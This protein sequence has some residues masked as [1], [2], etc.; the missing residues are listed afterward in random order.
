MSYEILNKA[1]DVT[2]FFNKPLHKVNKILLSYAVNSEELPEW[3]RGIISLDDLPRFRKDGCKTNIKVNTYTPEKLGQCCVLIV[4]QLTGGWRIDE[5][6]FHFENEM[7][8]VIFKL[9]WS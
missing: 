1:N 7:E 9:N 3:L 4:E 8:A 2:L 5:H 6:G